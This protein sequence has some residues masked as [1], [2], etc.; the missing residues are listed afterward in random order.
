MGNGIVSIFPE[1]G[2]LYF[3]AYKIPQV[4]NRHHLAA[5]AEALV[6]SGHGAKG[7]SA[8]FVQICRYQAKKSP[9]GAKSDGLWGDEG[10]DQGR[11][12]R[13]DRPLSQLKSR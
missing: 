1:E 7:R 9:A 6:K 11:R 3:E 10:G 12:T 2:F 5:A 8:V 4:K 13:L